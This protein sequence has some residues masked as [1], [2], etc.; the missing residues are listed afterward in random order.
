M[1]D[2]FS[3]KERDRLDA[4]EQK[5]LN[6]LRNYALEHN[7]PIASH[8]PKYEPVLCRPKTKNDIVK[9]NKGGL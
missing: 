5:E 6:R 7:L 9:M 1:S 8:K 4:E 2:K 3:M